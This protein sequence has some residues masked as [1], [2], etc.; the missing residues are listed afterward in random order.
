MWKEIDAAPA[1]AILGLT[2]AFK[3]DANPSKVNLGVGVYKDDQGTTPVLKCIKAAEKALIETQAS[4]G[5]LPIS[6]DPA[7][8][9]NVQK[10]LFGADSEVVASGRAATIQSPGGTGAL[11]VG[12]DLLKKFKPD[13]T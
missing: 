7:Y 4:K 9:T 1:D 3:K 8:A 13:A 2:E 10:L 12:A 6:G 11:R 5:Y